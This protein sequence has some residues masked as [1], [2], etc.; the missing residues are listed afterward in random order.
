MES[1]ILSIFSGADDVT[2][3]DDAADADAVDADESICIEPIF[4]KELIG[5]ID[6]M[7]ET[8]VVNFEHYWLDSQGKL[9]VIENIFP[10]INLRTI[11]IDVWDNYLSTHFEQILS[12]F[13][14]DRNDQYLNFVNI[15]RQY[16]RVH[17]KNIIESMYTQYPN[18]GRC[19]TL[20]TYIILCEA[21]N[22]RHKT[23]LSY[24]GIQ[25]F[26]N[27]RLYPYLYDTEQLKTLIEY[28]LSNS[29]YEPISRIFKYIQEFGGKVFQSIVNHFTQ[30]SKPKMSLK[31]MVNIYINKLTILETYFNYKTIRNIVILNYT[32]KFKKYSKTY[33]IFLLQYINTVIKKDLYLTR[34]I[35]SL[36]DYVVDKDIFIAKYIGGVVRRTINTTTFHYQDMRMIQQL[37]KYDLTDY[38]KLAKIMADKQQSVIINGEIAS[39]YPNY[40]TN[41]TYAASGM[42]PLKYANAYKAPS[43]FYKQQKLIETYIGCRYEKRKLY[44]NPHY[45]IGVIDVNLA[46]ASFEMEAPADIIELI[47]KFTDTDKISAAN[48][49]TDDS[50][51]LISIG[52]IES[53]DDMLHLNL[54]FKPD[55]NKRVI[56]RPKA[57]KKTAKKAD[58]KAAIHREPFIQAYIVRYM[59]HTESI[60]IHCDTL[61][62][63]CKTHAESRFSLERAM[64]DINLNKMV[65]MDLITISYDKM[66]E[67]SI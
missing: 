24:Y 47:L 49:A 2:D 62:E 27:A 33:D 48:I 11:F 46:G 63:N 51:A 59:K 16:H 35:L 18:I 53:R 10:N 19:G 15:I 22:L 42:W 34:T 12:G 32:Q 52:L 7:P 8:T 55:D 56:C 6:S 43:C 40:M 58:K 21:Y 67:Y 26:D 28:E 44:W 64:F 23:T 38:S 5:Y 25:N 20:E 9:V 37:Y 3:D 29:N 41:M 39:I 65:D 60:A 54:H 36:L 57:A 31:E 45:I 50:E 13:K 1:L 66:V 17:Y 61:Y 4:R 30:A 14:K